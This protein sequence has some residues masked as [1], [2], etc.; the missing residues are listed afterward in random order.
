MERPLLT[1]IIPLYEG[2][3][4]PLYTIEAVYNNLKGRIEDLTAIVERIKNK[5]LITAEEKESFEKGE[6]EREIALRSQN[7]E[8]TR[9]EL[10]ECERAWEKLINGTVLICDTCG[11]EISPDRKQAYPQSNKCCECRKKERQSRKMER[12]CVS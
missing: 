1:D 4:C 11:G 10:E 7:N 12:L 5:P 9:Q 6:D 3:G 8:A 2:R